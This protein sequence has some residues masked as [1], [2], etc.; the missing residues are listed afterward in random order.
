MANMIRV[1]AIEGFHALHDRMNRLFEDILG[2]SGVLPGADSGWVPA[3]D[4]Y[5]APEALVLKLEAPGVD[6][7]TIDIAVVGDHLEIAGRK[8]AEQPPKESRW[9]R[10]ERRTGEFRRTIPLP[11]PVEPGKVDA[12]AKHGLL[13]VLLPKKA[14]VMPKRITVKPG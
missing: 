8:P 5:E 4:I 1:P 13:T 10:F 6:P 9:Y 7:A 2:D 12:T 3:I 14:E 11:F